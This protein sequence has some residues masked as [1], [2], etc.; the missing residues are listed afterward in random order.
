MA[1]TRSAVETILVA[2]RGDLMAVVNF[3]LTVAGANAD[4]NDPIGWA[5]RRLGGSTTNFLS[6]ADADV[7]TVTEYPEDAIIDLAEWRLIMNIKG[8]FDKVDIT[9]G[10]FSEKLS[11]MADALASDLKNLMRAITNTYGIGDIPV[12]AG[13]VTLDFAQHGDDV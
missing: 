6:V 11:Q 10:P 5:I 3:A 2:R 8:N 7:I 4:L 12:D 13:I 1:L 9:S